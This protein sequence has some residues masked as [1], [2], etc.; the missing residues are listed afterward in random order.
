MM[1]Y[2]KFKEIDCDDIIHNVSIA[3]QLGILKK[4]VDEFLITWK[5]SDDMYARI[6]N[7]LPLKIGKQQAMDIFSDYILTKDIILP[8]YIEIKDEVETYANLQ[9]VL[10][11]Y[12]KYL[13]K[14]EEF[15]RKLCD[16]IKEDEEITKQATLTP[17]EL[18]DLTILK[19]NEKDLINLLKM[20]IDNID[21][22][23]DHI[24]DK[25]YG[26]I[27]D[28]INKNKQL[29]QMLSTILPF[30][31]VDLPFDNIYGANFPIFLVKT[32]EGNILPLHDLDQKNR[33]RFA[34]LSKEYI[35]KQTE[36]QKFM[37]ISDYVQS[38]LQREK[39]IKSLEKE[40]DFIKYEEHPIP[41]EHIPGYLRS[42][43]SELY[44]LEEEREKYYDA[45][46]EVDKHIIAE[47]LKMLEDVRS[48]LYSKDRIKN[49]S[50]K[51]WECK[52]NNQNVLLFVGLIDLKEGNMSRHANIIYLNYDHGLV[53]HFEPHGKYESFYDNYDV[54][55]AIKKYLYEIAALVEDI[56]IDELT[57]YSINYSPTKLRKRVLEDKAKLKF[58]EPV[59]FDFKYD[60]SYGPQAISEDSFCLMWSLYFTI[61]RLANLDL[62]YKEVEYMTKARVN[63]T[64][65]LTDEM[66][67]IKETDFFGYLRRKYMLL[68]KCELI[69]RIKRSML[70]YNI[71]LNMAYSTTDQS[72]FI[73]ILKN[74]LLCDHSYY[75]SFFDKPPS[76]KIKK[77]EVN[78]YGGKNNYKEIKQKYMKLKDSIINNL[79]K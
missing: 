31:I 10:V 71:L 43:Q 46:K 60:E 61:L 50:T 44:K 36:I 1:E 34:E 17:K 76:Q 78:Q 2:R 52:R 32:L 6:N 12:K 62:H 4:I 49:I 30:C 25:L 39:R 26:K 66:E 53:E 74:S 20:G 18:Y 73:K 42:L 77:K 5:L 68:D 21:K 11:E 7:T 70:F 24:I 79:T 67:K 23:F 22:S 8:D 41:E 3:K 37:E 48:A 35:I 72:E 40:I 58:A 16:K 63:P 33:E 29:F 9:I 47:N 56:S 69:Y 28:D 45:E 19:K 64:F 75:L 14:N 13:F 15:K 54:R 51:I 27:N 38:R 59:I 65:K 57:S 55:M